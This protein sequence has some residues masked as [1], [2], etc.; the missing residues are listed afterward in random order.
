[1]CN[2]S[3]DDDIENV[4]VISYVNRQKI[5]QALCGEDREEQGE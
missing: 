2:D 1:M 5:L 3:G 4:E